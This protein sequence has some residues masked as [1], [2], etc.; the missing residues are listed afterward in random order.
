[1]ESVTYTPTIQV[2]TSTEDSMVLIAQSPTLY[3]LRIQELSNEVA[4]IKRVWGKK[5]KHY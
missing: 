5:K 3:E 2:L 1:M 4:E